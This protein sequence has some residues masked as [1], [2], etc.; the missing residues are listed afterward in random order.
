MQTYLATLAAGGVRQ[1][2]PTIARSEVIHGHMLLALEAAGLAV[3]EE[4]PGDGGALR[5]LVESGDFS[6]EFRF[7]AATEAWFLGQAGVGD[8]HDSFA[9]VAD[10]TKLALE[11]ASRD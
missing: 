7:D 11:T 9:T 5:S 2:G 10:R 4:E 8:L 6:A 3:S 1:P